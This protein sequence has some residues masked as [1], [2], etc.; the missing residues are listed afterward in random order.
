MMK[1]MELEMQVL[2]DLDTIAYAA[3][4]TITPADCEGWIE[5]SGIYS[6]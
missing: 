1:A 2:Q 5:D 3:F 4:L 6:A